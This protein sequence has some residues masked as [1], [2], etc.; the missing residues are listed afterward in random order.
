VKQFLQE[1]KDWLGIHHWNKDKCDIVNLGF[2]MEIYPKKYSVDV[3]MTR[4]TKAVVKKEVNI[5]NDPPSKLV[6]SNPRVSGMH[7]MAY[8]VQ[9]QKV[10]A[11]TMIE[12]LKIAYKP[13]TKKDNPK[14]ILMSLKQ[15]NQKEFQMAIQL[16]NKFL[17]G[18]MGI[19]IEGIPQPV[20]KMN[21]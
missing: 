7:T 12:F 17:N 1:N 13:A 14:F 6:M 15:T 5:K 11:V 8:S 9:V 19:Q 10:S 20:D 21:L 18:L 4:V 3:A 2:I 16:Q